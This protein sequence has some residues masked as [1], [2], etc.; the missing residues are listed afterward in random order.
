MEDKIISN[1]PDLVFY[2]NNIKVEASTYDLKLVFMLS[3]D[4][5]IINQTTI[6]LSWPHAKRLQAILNDRINEYESMYSEILVEPNQE[7]LNKL[8]EEGKII[9]VGKDRR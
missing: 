3:E 6:F 7:I 9:P 8:I 2:S 4:K 5:S 1:E